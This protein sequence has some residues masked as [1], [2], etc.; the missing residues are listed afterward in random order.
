MASALRMNAEEFSLLNEYLSAHFGLNFPD[1]K[2]EILEF[3]LRPRLEAL[4]LRTFMEYYILLQY[5]SGGEKDQLARAVTNNETYFFRETLQL[6][7]L[8]TEGIDALKRDVATEGILSV[9]C[10]GCSSGEEAYTIS[11]FAKENQFRMWGMDVRIYAFDLDNTRLE[12][13]RNGLYGASSF[14][15]VDDDK[16]ERYFTKPR[17]G[18]RQVKGG[19]KSDIIFGWGNILDLYSYYKGVPFDIIF[20][21]NVL[22]YFSEA[23]LHRAVENFAKCLRPGGILFLGH[24]ESIIGLTDLFEPFRLGPCIVYRRTR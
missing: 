13:A 7:A 4:G 9:L 14:R 22:I 12:V 2:K 3:G 20:C 10:A 21:R 24:S 18:M 8:F 16:M 23:S 15:M 5:S 19:Y 11:I 1:H 6:E 17:D